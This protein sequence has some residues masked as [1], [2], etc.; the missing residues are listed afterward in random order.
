MTSD[1][2]MRSLFDCK[3]NPS[4]MRSLMDGY[5]VLCIQTYVTID[6]IKLLIS[7][8][9]H[10]LYWDRS[11]KL[12]SADSINLEYKINN[13]IIFRIMD[14]VSHF[15]VEI[16]SN[17]DRIDEISHAVFRMRIFSMDNRAEE[18][19]KIC[20]IT[21]ESYESSNI[22]FASKH[23]FHKASIMGLEIELL[24]M[25]YSLN[26]Q[27]DRDDLYRNLFPLTRS[28]TKWKY[29]FNEDVVD[30][31]LYENDDYFRDRFGPNCFG[32]DG[33]YYLFLGDVLVLVFFE[34]MHRITDLKYG[35][36]S[37]FQD[38]LVSIN[39]YETNFCPKFVNLASHYKSVKR[40]LRRNFNCEGGTSSVE[41]LY[42][43]IIRFHDRSLEQSLGTCPINITKDGNCW[44]VKSSKNDIQKFTQN[45]RRDRRYHYLTRKKTKNTKTYINNKKKHSYN[46]W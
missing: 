23:G 36:L 27:R 8:F 33:K 26:R 10:I 2:N 42:Q 40:R 46:R 14:Y 29:P 37:K 35:Y 13:I 16:A 17:L 3:L 39:D 1:S 5:A 38:I 31:Q 28:W 12:R 34:E 9:N 20:Q 6:I 30:K 41:K 18:F 19:N 32:V 24:R 15:K 4:R 43:S 22:S 25:E 7:Y 44:V 21:T 45:H 11:Q